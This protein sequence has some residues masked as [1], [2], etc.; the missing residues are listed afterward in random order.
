MNDGT[1]TAAQ[2]LE[3]QD[4]PKP[5]HILAA[6]HRMHAQGDGEDQ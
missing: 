3:Q 4:D 5:E 1:R 6:A 2:G